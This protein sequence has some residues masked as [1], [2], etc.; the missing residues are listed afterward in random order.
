M[1]R[2][3]TAEILNFIGPEIDIVAPDMG[4]NEQVMFWIMDPYS[5]HKGYSVP[6]IVTGKPVDIG[7]TLGREEATGRGLV[8]TIVEAAEHFKLNLKWSSAVVQGFGN[9]GM[10]AAKDLA[11]L[12]VKVTAVSDRSGALFNEHGMDLE[13]IILHKEKSRR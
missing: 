8:Y 9:V 2:R 10:V 13:E 11:A 7:G 4:T 6:D 1:T 5:Q 12:G 3:F